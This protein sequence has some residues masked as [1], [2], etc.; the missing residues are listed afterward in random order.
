M[1]SLVFSIWVLVACEPEPNFFD[2]TKPHRYRV[3]RGDSWNTIASK[4]NTRPDVLREWNCLP[5]DHLLIPGQILNIFPGGDGAPDC[6]AAVADAELA[7]APAAETA[8]TAAPSGAIASGTPATSAPA[9]PAPQPR[10]TAAPQPAAAPTPTAGPAVASASPSPAPRQPQSLQVDLPAQG[11]SRMG[12]GGTHLLSLLDQVDEG[13]ELTAVPSIQGR[14]SVGGNSLDRRSSLGGGGSAELGGV[15]IAARERAKPLG[16]PDAI[17]QL[18]KAQ[19]KQCKA[20]RLRQSEMGDRDMVASSGLGVAE[21][22]A[23]MRPVLQAALGCLPKDATGQWEVHLEVSLGCDGMVYDTR[24]TQTGGLPSPVTA[25]L[26]GV[27]DQASFAA[28]EG[29]TTFL[30]PIRLAR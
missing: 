25:C 2:P 10:G 20:V 23:G 27:A 12:A 3:L 7:P 9:A 26:E 5:E 24:T 15:D 4:R 29:A 8:P 17:P 21:I 22:K 19:P 30:Y 28:A 1:I 18:P 16:G 11:T 6:D 13:V 14:A